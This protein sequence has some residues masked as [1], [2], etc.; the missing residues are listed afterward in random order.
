MARNAGLI[1]VDTKYEFGLIDGRPVL[2]DEV[3]T[4]D[5]SRYWVASSYEPV[6]GTDQEPENFDKEF[7]RLWFAAQG[8][9]GDGQPPAIARTCKVQ[10]AQRYIAIYERLTGQTFV[11]G[12]QPA[13]ER[14]CRGAGT[15]LRVEE[16]P[17]HSY[18]SS[19][20]LARTWRT[21]RRSPMR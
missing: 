6:R 3:H 4:P 14:I 2:I 10:V 12:E 11:A 5:S 20:A 8:Y 21:R 13:A 19:W 15:E 9:R 17:C 7:L 1:L 16:L 18:R